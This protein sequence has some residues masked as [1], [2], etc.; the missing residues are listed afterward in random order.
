MNETTSDSVRNVLFIMC[1]QLRLDALS[2]FGGSVIETPNID[3][4]AAR[5][6][7][8]DQAHVQG[9][10]CGSSRM[11]FY[12]GRYV[13]SHGARYNRIPLSIG[14]RTL[15]DHLRSQGVRTMLI[16]KTHM[17][18][19]RDGLATLGLDPDAPEAMYLAECGFEPTLR[20]DGLRAIFNGDTTVEEVL[21]YT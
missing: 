4:L 10:V 3:R 8:F 1:D 7:R 19:D 16:G 18:P 11:S 9:S 2:C 14:Q 21:K 5:G 6:V 17:A 20:D 12:T 13:Q 15:G